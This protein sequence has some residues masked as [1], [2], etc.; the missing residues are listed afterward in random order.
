M[1]L[2][3]IGK[4]IAMGIAAALVVAFAFGVYSCERLWLRVQG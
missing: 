1:T 2:H 3:D 4:C